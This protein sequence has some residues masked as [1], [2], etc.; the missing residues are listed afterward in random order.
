[1]KLPIGTNV[2]S[3]KEEDYVK[4]LQ[5]FNMQFTFQTPARF[6]S[7]QNTTQMNNVHGLILKY[8]TFSLTVL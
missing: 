2:F 6:V 1:M 8:A 4:P 3:I 5:L 7:P